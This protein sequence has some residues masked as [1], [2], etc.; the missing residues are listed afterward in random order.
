MAARELFGGA[1]SVQ[2]DPRF[3]D[4]S[5]F[6]QIPDTQEVFADA[7]TDQSVIVDILEIHSSSNGV[8][9]A[10][11]HFDV[12]ATD[13]SAIASVVVEEVPELQVGA[14]PTV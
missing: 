3:F 11:F 4:V 14:A 8:C 13:N 9:P 1:L 5:N 10:H 6:R 12:L 7:T 2:L